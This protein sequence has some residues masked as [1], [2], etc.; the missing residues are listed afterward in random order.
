MGPTVQAPSRKFNEGGPVQEKKVTRS[1][2]RLPLGKSQGH[3]WSSLGARPARAVAQSAYEL[4]E[5][6]RDKIAGHRP[7]TALLRRTELLPRKPF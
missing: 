1:S 4:V 3:K 5:S 2:S 6:T 7:D